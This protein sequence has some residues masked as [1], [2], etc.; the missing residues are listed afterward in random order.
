[1]NA[2]RMTDY[3]GLFQTFQ[4]SLEFPDYFGHNT[5]AF[6]E[7]ITDMDWLIRD[8]FWSSSSTRKIC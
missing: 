5:N 6:L 2:N 3:P 8:F 7:C 1:L 4:N